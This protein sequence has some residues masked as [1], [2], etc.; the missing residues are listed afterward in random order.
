MAAIRCE[1]TKTFPIM[2]NQVGEFSMDRIYNGRALHGEKSQHW[3]GPGEL[4]R[5]EIEIESDFKG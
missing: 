2:K 1:H 4:Y 5:R 3:S